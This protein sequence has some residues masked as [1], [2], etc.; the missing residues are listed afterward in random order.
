MIA[1]LG[2]WQ[3]G[4]VFGEGGASEFSAGVGDSS[5]V[6]VG[7]DVTPRRSRHFSSR[8]FRYRLARK[9]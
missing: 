8:S 4:Q 3:A 7:T 2:R 1:R 6:D 5:A 9:P